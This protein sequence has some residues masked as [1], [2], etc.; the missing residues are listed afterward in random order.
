MSFH[1]IR[2]PNQTNPSHTS[3]RADLGAP[4]ED[5][6]F[7]AK[8]ADLSTKP[9]ADCEVV[10]DAIMSAL[11]HFARDTRPT[12]HLR[13]QLR[14]LPSSGGN[15]ATGTEP[16]TAKDIHAAINLGPCSAM[17]AAFEANLSIE[18]TG[19]EG[20]RSPV[21]DRVTDNRTG[22]ADH[23]TPSDVLEIEGN[24]FEIDP[25]DT[26]QGVFFA[27]T[28]GSPIRATRY[29]EVSKTHISI[30]VPASVSGSVILSVASKYDT[31]SIRT[32]HYP[33]AL[34]Q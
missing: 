9:Q 21:I 33:T 20:V 23:Y 16:H 18:R 24:N 11:V 32:G 12:A 4:V 26:A 34:T 3:T 29:I 31:T 15:F 19:E 14:M 22:T 27:P 30:L 5:D 8:V 7:F 13:D 10:F 28:S 25:S 6:E 1:Y 17:V 2:R